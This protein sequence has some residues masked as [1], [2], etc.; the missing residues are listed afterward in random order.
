MLGAGTQRVEEELE[1]AFPDARVLRM[2]LDTTGRKDAHHRL[3][4]KFGKGKADILLG[5]QMVAKGLDFGRVTLVGIIN[6]DAGMLLPD[7]RAE[8]RSFQL[9][10]QVAGRAG[11]AGLRGEVVL[12]TRN[13]K[14]PVIQYA[15]MHDYSGYVT[16]ALDEREGMGYPPFGRIISISFR[17][18]EKE[19]L[20]DFAAKWTHALKTVVNYLP[21]QVLGPEPAFINR[22]KRQYR[23]QTILK[24]SESV[25]PGAIHPLLKKLQAEFAKGPKDIRVAVD[26]DPAG[27]L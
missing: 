22:V 25:R 4:D 12:Q 19:A 20:D 18:S 13:P 24:L 7:F 17:G 8:E 1:A 10:T 15:S 27:T 11:R 9:L 26:I 2:D 14:S 3:L 21:I 5:T 16:A 23:F 6:A